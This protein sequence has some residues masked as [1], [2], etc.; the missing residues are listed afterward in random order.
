MEQFASASPKTFR[1][2]FTTL[3]DD[4]HD[5]GWI[6]K[7]KSPE[8]PARLC[9][10]YPTWMIRY[11]LMLPS[12]LDL[13]GSWIITDGTF[14]ISVWSRFADLSKPDQSSRYR[15]DC[16]SASSRWSAY[17]QRPFSAFHPSKRSAFS[18]PASIRATFALRRAGFD[19]YRTP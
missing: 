13:S 3:I 7:A 15:W 6:E 10:S 1:T 12:D 17:R 19:R 8:K 16:R 11:G 5:L 9:R 14:D 18:T 2:T 4:L